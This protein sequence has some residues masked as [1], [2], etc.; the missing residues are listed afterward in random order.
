[1]SDSQTTAITALRE[2]ASALGA[3]RDADGAAGG[4][5]G[6]QRPTIAGEVAAVLDALIGLLRS[7]DHDAAAT[8][9]GDTDLDPVL[10]HLACGATL[11]RSV[12]DRG[13]P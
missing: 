3:G 6:D 4:L 7:I 9:P 10:T 13:S 5:T 1:M 8:G 2:A 11:A 12:E